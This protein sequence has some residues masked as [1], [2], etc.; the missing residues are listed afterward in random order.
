MCAALRTPRA[1]AEHE[2]RNISVL[3]AEER[4]AALWE[5]RGRRARR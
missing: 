1:L 5:V 3:P 2:T 4:L